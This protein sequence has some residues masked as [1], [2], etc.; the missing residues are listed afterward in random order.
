MALHRQ[1][2]VSRNRE[3]TSLHQRPHPEGPLSPAAEIPGTVARFKYLGDPVFLGAA[4]LYLLNRFVLKKGFGG[5]CTLLRNHW[6]DFLL[7][8]AALPP[9]LWSFHKLGLRAVPAPPSG[10]EIIKWTALWSLT[11]EWVFP[12]LF[13]KGTADWKDILCYVGGAILGWG[14][15]RKIYG[16]AAFQRDAKSQSSPPMPLDGSIQAHSVRAYFS[17]IASRYDLANHLLS[18]GMDLVWRLRAAELVQAWQPQRILD[19]ATGSGDLARTLRRAC[20]EALIVGA[21]FCEPM[22]QIACKKRLPNLVVA[23]GL[24]LPFDSNAFDVVTVAFGLRNMASW[25]AALAEMRRVLLPGGH[26]LILDFGMPSPPFLGA[27]RFYLHSILPGI[28]TLL[29]G[30]R[31]AYDYLADSIETFPNGDAMCR[32]LAENG[33]E[34]TRYR[35]LLGGI[36]AIYTGT[37][38]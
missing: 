32:R 3:R 31:S 21:D 1:T 17:R 26:L 9:L 34:E 18:G 16:T 30:E 10:A 33:F 8:P 11:F 7:L 13:H 35:P 25:T 19:L 15:W 29:T 37:R 28:A 20:P 4:S 22:L 2:P 14:L 36:A 38:A 27:Y 23:D 12:Y 5:E 24:Q 6:D